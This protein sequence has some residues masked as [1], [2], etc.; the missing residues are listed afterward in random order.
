MQ[1]EKLLSPVSP[2]VAC[3]L[4]G[5]DLLLDT[6]T[7]YVLEYDY[8]VDDSKLL[9]ALSQ[10]IELYPY[11]SGRK[12]SGLPQDHKVYIDCFKGIGFNF[13]QVNT[14]YADECDSTK[15]DWQIYLPD[16]SKRRKHKFSAT[17]LKAPLFSVKQTNYH[18]HTILGF[19]VWHAIA[20]GGAF[21]NFLTTLVAAYRGEEVGSYQQKEC[22][23][24]NDEI[25]G[26][27]HESIR[28]V[29]LTSGAREAE[30]AIVTTEFTFGGDTLDKLVKHLA[31]HGIPLSDYLYALA[32]KSSHHIMLSSASDTEKSSLYTVYDIR[33][34]TDIEKPLGNH[35]YYPKTE[36]TSTELRSLTSLDIAKKIRSSVFSMV[37]HAEQIEQELAWLDKHITN[38]NYKQFAV[39]PVYDAIY[40]PAI[41]CNNLMHISYDSFDFGHGK[42]VSFDT[43]NE[44]YMRFISILPSRVQGGE[45]R[46]RVSLFE[47]ELA[48]FESNFNNELKE[49]F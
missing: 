31:P 41:M 48:E 16:S 34:F 42:P 33:Q 39:R 49:F 2:P 8:L 19:S 46:F 11:F 15:Q 7:D 18:D 29:S 14:S 40:E 30:S 1:Y 4:G 44:E 43:P 9:A 25:I 38:K 23:S 32:W 6:W 21:F 27:Y 20:D 45:I 10:A 36:L 22:A 35:L 3:A 24:S 12:V 13:H 5:V 28:Q 47:P 26:E 17:S 37:E